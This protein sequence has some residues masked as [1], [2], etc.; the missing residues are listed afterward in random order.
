MRI[1]SPR[2][3]LR[4]AALA[5]LGASAGAHLGWSA[6]AEMSPSRVAG[7]APASSASPSD[8]PQRPAT[9][10][11]ASLTSGEDRYGGE[12]VGCRTYPEE[13]Q[14]LHD[15]AVEAGDQSGRQSISDEA[16]MRVASSL[17]E[18]LVELAR[19]RSASEGG[20]HPRGA[21][22]AATHTDPAAAADDE[23]SEER[24]PEVNPI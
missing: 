14:P 6:V 4:I 1:A 24:A 8:T 20:D 22:V 18:T 11:S 12:C 21:P 15:P 16:S 10:A 17:A 13:Y 3:S 23:T 2:P 9:P 5:L 19:R 7:K